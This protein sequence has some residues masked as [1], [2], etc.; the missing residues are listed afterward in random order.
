MEDKRQ[1]LLRRELAWLRRG[2]KARTT[3]QKARVDRV[4]ELRDRKVDGPSGSLDMSL[5]A[6]V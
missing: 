6:S 5:G 4:V 3:K 2:A 1:N